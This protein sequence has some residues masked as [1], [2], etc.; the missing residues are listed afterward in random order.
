MDTY[1]YIYIDIHIYPRPVLLAPLPPLDI[2]DS[3]ARGAARH[4]SRE[5]EHFR[6]ETE[7]CGRGKSEFSGEPDG[8]RCFRG[9][10]SFRNRFSPRC[11][12]T[13]PLK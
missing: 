12:T 1:I 13:K 5:T 8:E 3:R 10:S 11:F 2:G 6:R 4:S 9:E 7:H